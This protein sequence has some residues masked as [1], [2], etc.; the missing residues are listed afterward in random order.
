VDESAWATPLL[1]LGPTVAM[2]VRLGR[3]IALDPVVLLLEHASAPLP[4]EDTIAFA[5][6]VRAIAEQRA[7][8]VV[9]LTADEAFA[10]A[11][12]ATVLLHEPATGRLKDGA[13]G[14]FDL[15]RRR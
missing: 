14:W 1:Q 10:R 13:R 12:A 8:A 5:E 4:R 15:L 9:A 7:I 2:R 3:A 6:R 11:L